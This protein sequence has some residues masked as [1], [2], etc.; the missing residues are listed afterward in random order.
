VQAHNVRGLAFAEAAGFRREAL[1]RNYVVIDG[2]CADRVRLG[3]LL[4]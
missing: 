3:K 2:R 4:R 1:A